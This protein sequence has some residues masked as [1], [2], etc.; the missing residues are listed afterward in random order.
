[1]VAHWPPN[2]TLVMATNFSDGYTS[3]SSPKFDLISSKFRLASTKLGGYARPS[4]G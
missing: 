4:P 3:A 2:S 1:M